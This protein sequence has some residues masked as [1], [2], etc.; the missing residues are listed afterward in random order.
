MLRFVQTM[1][2]LPA[3]LSALVLGAHASRNGWPLAVVVLLAATPLLLIARKLWAVR[4]VQAVLVLGAA[5]WVRTLLRLVEVRQ[6]HGMSYVRM[7]SILGAVAAV[8]LLGAWL[9]GRWWAAR[10]E[11]VPGGER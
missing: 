2:L 3:I 11:P 5:E 4:V 7:A 6:A 1:R 9:V 10:T 8:S